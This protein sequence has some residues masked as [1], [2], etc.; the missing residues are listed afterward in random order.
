MSA[1]II[2]WSATL[3][4][5]MLLLAMAFAAYRLI[6]GPRAQDRVMAIDAIYN[7]GILQALVLAIKTGNALYLPFILIL[8]ILG[9]VSTVALAKFL[10]RGE[11]IE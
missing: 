1:D 3:A 10:M 8:A 5:G 7:I 6:K 4:Q 9:F 2:Y 11:V